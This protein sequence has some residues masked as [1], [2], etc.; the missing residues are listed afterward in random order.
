MIPR[1]NDSSRPRLGAGEPIRSDRIGDGGEISRVRIAS[2]VADQFRS[3]QSRCTHLATKLLASV[4]SL[5]CMALPCLGQP[6]LAFPNLL[7]Q[8]LMLITPLAFDLA[9]SGLSGIP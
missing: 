7:S 1:W 5:A 8:P 3:G 9:Q 4:P 6:L 2:R